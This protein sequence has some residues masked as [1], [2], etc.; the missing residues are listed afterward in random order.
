[1]MKNANDTLEGFYGTENY[2]KHFLGAVYTDGVKT[3]AE[4]FHCYWLL[5]VIASHQTNKKVRF[6]GFQ[7]WKLQRIKD[8]KFLVT[9]DDGNGNIVTQQKIPFSDF[10]YD[11]ATIWFVGGVMLLPSEY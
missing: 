9:C 7:V 5:D 10:N 2:H 6:E 4:R 3:M 8:T 1:M 11:E